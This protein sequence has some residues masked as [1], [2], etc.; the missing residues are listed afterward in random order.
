MPFHLVVDVDYCVRTAYILATSNLPVSS[1]TWPGHGKSTHVQGVVPDDRLSVFTLLTFAGLKQIPSRCRSQSDASKQNPL[2]VYAN[3]I[4]YADRHIKMRLFVE[5]EPFS[6]PRTS[7]H[8]HQVRTS[9]LAPRTSHLTCTC[10][11][12][13]TSFTSWFASSQGGYQPITTGLRHAVGCC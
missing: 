8:G 1:V 4:R 2:C 6:E 12:C 11:T 13:T 7:F 9:H 10:T 5:T 3:Q